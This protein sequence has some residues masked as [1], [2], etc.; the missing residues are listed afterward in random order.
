[1]IDKVLFGELGESDMAKID[2]AFDKII[3]IP[4]KKYENIYLKFENKI[5]ENEQAENE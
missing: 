3:Y 2:E 1:M 4:I 5:E